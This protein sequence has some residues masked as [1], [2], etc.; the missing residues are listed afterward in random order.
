MGIK[1]VCKQQNN[2]SIVEILFFFHNISFIDSEF[3]YFIVILK[4]KMTRVWHSKLNRHLGCLLEEIWYL[5]WKC[6]EGSVATEYHLITL[7]AV[8]TFSIHLMI[9]LRRN[10]FFDYSFE[11]CVTTDLLTV[12]AH[13][14][15]DLL[16]LFIW[17]GATEVF[18][19]WY[20][21]EYLTEFVIILVFRNLNLS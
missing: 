2:E 11:S 20:C 1:P 7:F 5:S 21:K 17:L 3:L 15:I 14:S 18:G 8:I 12:V 13:R 10:I 16:E 19:T 9:T 4:E 6:W